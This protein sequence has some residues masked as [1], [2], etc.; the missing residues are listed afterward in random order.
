MLEDSNIQL[1]HG[2]SFAGYR[3]VCLRNESNQVLMLPSL[4]VHIKVGDYVPS[5]LA[6][7]ADALS[8]PIA[9]ISEIDKRARMLEELAADTYIIEVRSIF[10][11]TL[12]SVSKRSL[13]ESVIKLKFDSFIW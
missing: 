2:I 3:H 5:G 4:F 7:F 10:F 6:G 9:H 12:A 8:N 11:L 13:R 1:F